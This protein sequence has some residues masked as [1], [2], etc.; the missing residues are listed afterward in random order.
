[1]FD[2][3]LDP[4]EYLI[5]RE[6]GRRM[7]AEA[8]RCNPDARRRVEDAYGVERCMQLYPEAYPLTNRLCSFVRRKLR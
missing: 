1:V 7:A 2:L 5:A 4:N 3:H 6:R 8:V